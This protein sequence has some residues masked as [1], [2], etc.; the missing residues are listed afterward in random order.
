MCD[1]FR[2]IVKAA[3]LHAAFMGVEDGSYLKKL[4]VSLPG[5]AA[6]V[7]NQ[8]LAKIFLEHDAEVTRN[9]RGDLPE[10]LARLNGH[11]NMLQLL[12]TFAV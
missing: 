9:D 2:F 6:F 7:G 5:G 10:D 3:S 1:S 4:L 12:H 8:A 11:V